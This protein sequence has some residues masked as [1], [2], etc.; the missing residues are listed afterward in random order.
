MCIKA[1]S[2]RA[3]P[4]SM[5][6]SKSTISLTSPPC[7]H[8]LA[9]QVQR[10]RTNTC[11][12][13]CPTSPCCLLSWL[14]QAPNILCHTSRRRQGTV[15]PSRQ[16]ASFP[17]LQDNVNKGFPQHQYRHHQKDGRDKNNPG[18]GHRPTAC[19]RPKSHDCLHWMV[20]GRQ[21]ARQQGAR[22]SRHSYLACYRDLLTVLP[23][24]TRPPAE[25]TL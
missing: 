9:S 21:P 3:M 20:E 19:P 15:W 6:P 12:S 7:Q 5:L 18:L 2:P 16:I 25:A 10:L 13:T 23:D 11:S 1:S 24:S 8:A 4:V 22:V 14:S 17:R